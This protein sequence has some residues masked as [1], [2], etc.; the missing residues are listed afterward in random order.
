MGHVS[1]SYIVRDVVHRGTVVNGNR[2]VGALLGGGWH[3]D[4]DI[5][6]VP[7]IL[8]IRRTSA[9][10]T[11]PSNCTCEAFSTGARAGSTVCV[12]I[13]RLT[14]EKVSDCAIRSRQRN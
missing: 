3:T 8:T 12:A 2:K 5:V 1:E 10:V 14:R 4:G 7:E 9:R 6:I 11:F 13:A